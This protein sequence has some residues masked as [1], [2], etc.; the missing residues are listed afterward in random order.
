[1]KL[2]LGILAFLSLF[3]VL[4][5]M[6]GGKAGWLHRKGSSQWLTRTEKSKWMDVRAGSRHSDEL[7]RPVV[8]M[9]FP[10]KAIS[11][12]ALFG[13]GEVQGSPWV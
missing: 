6:K 3:M 12:I 4:V 10:K 11:R 7:E 9:A 2:L 8:E 5:P 1:M 13:A